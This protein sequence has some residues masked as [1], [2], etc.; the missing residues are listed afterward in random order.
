MLNSTMSSCFVVIVMVVVIA[1]SYAVADG[2]TVNRTVEINSQTPN[3]PSLEEGDLFGQSVSGIG[4][5]DGDDIPD[6]AV[7]APG[8]H[9][10]GLG[11]GDLFIMFLNE[12]GSV[13]DTAEINSQ[14][15][16]G[17]S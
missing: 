16:N 8:H 7:G 6:I 3:G 12:D 4:Y 14:T 15:P 5:L 17:P 9:A 2:A 13:K 11:T 10:L 1:T